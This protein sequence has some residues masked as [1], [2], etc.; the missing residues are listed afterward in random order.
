MGDKMKEENINGY[1]D[2]MT[3]L[4]AEYIRSLRIDCGCTWRRICEIYTEIHFGNGSF[5][6][7]QLIG[8]EICSK[9]QDLLKCNHPNW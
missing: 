2:K 6:E 4:E 3:N 1:L 8:K 7:N 9:A 5:I